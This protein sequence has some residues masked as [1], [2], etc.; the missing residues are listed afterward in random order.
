MER[1]FQTDLPPLEPLDMNMVKGA[2]TILFSTAKELPRAAP[3]WSATEE[4]SLICAS[5]SYLSVGPR[6]LEGIG[7]EHTTKTAEK[8]THAKRELVSVLVN[9]Q[10]ALHTPCSAH[11]SNGTLNDKR[12]GQKGMLGTRII[13]VLC[14]WWN[15]VF[16]AMVR[17]TV[18]EGGDDTSLQTGT[19]FSADDGERVQCSRSDAWGWH[20]TSLGKS[21]LNLLTDMSNAFSCTKRETM[22]EANE[23]CDFWMAQRLRNGVFFFFAGTRWRIDVHGET[24]F[25]HGDVGGATYL[26]LGLRQNLSNGGKRA[27]KHHRP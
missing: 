22:E 7:V 1:E 12:D 15:S 20:L 3:C 21:H 11:N 23:Q 5:P 19:A 24:R 10:R 18:S 25:A 27:I 26:L 6:R 17:E 8:Y 16:A 2:K 9:A 14:S 4:L 13:H